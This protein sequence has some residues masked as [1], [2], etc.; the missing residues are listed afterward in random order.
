MFWKTASTGINLL[1]GFIMSIIFARFLGKDSYGELILVYTVISLF[2][3]MSNFGLTAALERFIPLYIKRKDEKKFMT[4]IVSAGI[5]GK[6]EN[7]K[8]N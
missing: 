5:A 7:L 1:A 6:H 8:T 2:I 3:S 4:F